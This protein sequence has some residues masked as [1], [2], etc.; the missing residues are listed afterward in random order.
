[1][2]TEIIVDQALIPFKKI[3]VETL[4]TDMEFAEKLIF[5]ID[6]A[7]AEHVPDVS[8][9]TGRKAIAS[10]AYEVSRSKTFLDE[11]IKKYVSD[12]KAKAKR[13]D[14]IRK[15]IRDRLDEIR[16]ARRKPLTDYEVAE[17]ER[18]AKE[19]AEFQLALDW[20]EAIEY[21]S[22]INKKREIDR[23]EAELSKFEAAQKAKEAAEKAEKDR[24]DREARIAKEAKEKAEQAAKEAVA[25]SKRDAEEA[26][27]RRIAAEQAAKEAAEKASRQAE[28]DKQNAIAEA[29]RQ[30]EQAELRKQAAIA[31][32][33]EIERQRAIRDENERIEKEAAV[34]ADAEL[35]SKDIEHRININNEALSCFK[36]CGIETEL[37]KKIIALIENGEIDHISINY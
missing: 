35:K 8:T 16:D 34:R 7:S 36:I 23:R 15:L 27:K 14:S 28:I 13:S 32:A 17:A 22:F 24:V 3:T 9:V 20:D 5:A 4:S 25:K 30:A 1:M 29:N 11:I 18:I 33:V 21:N 37:A 6:Q 31:E 19:K 26:E 12:I 10:N 2:Q